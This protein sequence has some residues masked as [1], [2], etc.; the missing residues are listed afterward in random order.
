MYVKTFSGVMLAIVDA[1]AARAPHNNAR[2]IG[3]RGAGSLFQARQTWLKRRSGHNSEG[4]YIPSLL[5]PGASSDQRVS[6]VWHHAIVL[7]A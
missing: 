6:A 7:A 2:H 5:D 4:E 1:L 3:P